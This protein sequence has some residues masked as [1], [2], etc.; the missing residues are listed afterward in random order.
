MTK[1]WRTVLLLCVGLLALLL[2]L[3]AF[4]WHQWQGFKH[5]QGIEQ[6]D[7]QGLRLSSSGISAKRVR[8]I[9]AP[10]N[11]PSLATEATNI[12]LDLA[13][14]FHP[15]PPRSLHIEQLELDIRSFTSAGDSE[16]PATNLEQYERWA[17]WLPQRLTIADLRV[18]LPCAKGRCDERGA[19]RF[20][21]KGESLL[22]L[23]GRLDL[24]RN[25]HRLSMI[26]DAQS[27]GPG[28]SL[29]LA[30]LAIDD[31]PRLEARNRLQHSGKTLQWDGTLSM[32]SLPE[33]PWLLDWLG[34][35]TATPTTLPDMPTDMRIG[36]GWALALAQT[37]GGT[38]DW[39][40]AAGELRLSA[41][42]PAA[43]PIIGLG[44]LQGD[45]DLVARGQDGLWL[46][47]ELK[48]NLQLRPASTLLTDVPAALRPSQLNISVEPV[49]TQVTPGQLPMQL[50]LDTQGGAPSSLQARMRLAT[51]P[52][53]SL[54][55]EQARLQTRST[56]L[57]LDALTL[58][59]LDATLDFSGRADLQKVELQLQ[60][61]SQAKLARLATGEVVAS[62]LS[63]TL[64][65]TLALQIERNL[66]QPTAWRAEGPLE[67]RLSRL[68]HPLLLAQGWR[69]SGQ[70]KAGSTALNANGSLS[71][72]AGLTMALNLE[73][74]WNGPLQVGGKLQE[75]F[76]RAGNP[77][78]GSLVTWPASLELSSGRLSGE[79]KLTL[80][81]GNGKP[82]ANLTLEAR[83][84]AGIF[85]RSEISGLDARVTARLQRD[86]LR[87]DISELRLAELNPGFT[88]GPLLWRGHYEAA[89]D[90]PAK[91]RLTWQIAE[92]QILGG[93]FWLPAGAL[94]LAAPQQ[95][96]SARLEGVQLGDVLAAY[97]T[98]GLS[99]SG[100]IDG[101]FDVQRSAEGLSVRDGKLAARA[102]G[103][104]LRFRS[105]KIEA[106][107]QANPA[108]KIVTEALH[109][110]HYDLL[111]SDVRYDENG[112]LNL[113]LRLNGHNPALE[114]GRPIN[115]SIN[116][117][118]D[119]PA[120]LTSLQLSDRVSETI[121]RRVQE[122]LRQG[123]AD[124][125]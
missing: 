21:R 9:Q 86:R 11:G 71:N 37:V 114:G 109:D 66:E 56:R 78:A 59:N 87:L 47:T 65:R 73:Q 49:A 75:I 51:S 42:I 99:G 122:R 25:E 82:T 41:H 98:E 115:F 63:V 117:E 33:A 121:Q 100:V 50:R 107:G 58:Q 38:Y 43:W 105:P 112:K 55:I 124:P 106:L 23:A 68:E 30:T 81:A 118:E 3:A 111:T 80:P 54:D 119:I 19:L 26:I 17:A 32:G 2:V 29:V 16:P 52:P 31:Q 70:L 125:Q 15:L 64:P 108:M 85:D 104:V 84:L 8:Y 57:Q 44:E 62:Q 46:P 24:R 13:S 97:P 77:I 103:G 1:P 61:S 36:A 12:T 69:W 92:T 96:L 60:K 83:G 93:R 90:Q 35:W 22:P 74:R 4:A 7:W 91:G 28:D 39:P 10:E 6:L 79:G 102:P 110:F 116:L 101:S 20:E 120:L 89:I 123:N 40:N 48:A 95:R 53:Y 34:E 88:F 14:L 72:D 5:E 76:L 94:D 18:S 67:L 113:G 27:A 45:L